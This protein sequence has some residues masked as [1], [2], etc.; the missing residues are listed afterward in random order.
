MGLRQE[1]VSGGEE[2]SPA[3]RA[4]KPVLELQKKQWG[5]GRLSQ[6]ELGCVFILSRVYDRRRPFCSASRITCLAFGD[7]FSSTVDMFMK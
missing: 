2:R 3:E 5:K 6:G 4:E 1:S 7:S